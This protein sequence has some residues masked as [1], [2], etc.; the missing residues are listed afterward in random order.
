M[1]QGVDN[2]ILMVTIK[3]NNLEYILL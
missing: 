1:V 2:K 3:H